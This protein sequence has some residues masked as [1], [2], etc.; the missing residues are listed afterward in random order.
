MKNTMKLLKIVL[1][2][3]ELLEQLQVNEITNDQAIEKFD[4]VLDVIV[5][6][7]DLSI[8]FARNQ[9]D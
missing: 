5:K 1:K 4:A 6:Q 7:A 8:K 9:V 3:Y 2:V